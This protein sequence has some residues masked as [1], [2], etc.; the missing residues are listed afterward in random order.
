MSLSELPKNYLRIA[1]ISFCWED[2]LLLKDCNPGQIV[3]TL[4]NLMSKFHVPC[5]NVD[6]RGGGVTHSSGGMG[7]CLPEIF[8]IYGL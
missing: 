7:A 5:K 1:D 2:D 3:G 6:Y 4:F 8:E